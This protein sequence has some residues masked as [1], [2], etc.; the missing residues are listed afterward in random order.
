MRKR[1]YLDNNA[2][3][4]LDPR[5]I[6]V[7]TAEINEIPANPSS[8]HHFGHEARTK[9]TKA[10]RSIATCLNT[11][12]QEIIF[13][14]SGTEAIN[15]LLRGIFEGNPSGHVITS[16]VEHPAVFHTLKALE[17][18]GVQVSYLPV[19]AWGAVTPDIVEKAIRGDTRL[20]TLM[21]A[22][23]ET[24]VMTDLAAI[25]AIAYALKIPFVV[26]GVAWLGKAPLHI[27]QGVSAIAFSGH[28][29]H[30]PKGIGFAFVK[31]DLPLMPIVTGGGQEYNRRSGTENLAAI[32]A[33]AEA[34]KI[35]KDNEAHSIEHISRLRC[36]F[37]SNLLN[38]LNNLLIAGEGPK[39]ANTSNIAF[40]G[41][42]AE[43]FLMNLDL[44][45]IAASHGSACSSGALEP[46]RVLTNMGLTREAVKSSIR[47]SLSRYT[48]EEEIL[49]AVEVIQQVIKRLRA[50]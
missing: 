39:I 46:S 26:D 9:L 25:G 41:I 4:A 15:M 17:M 44:L 19:G 33:L 24:G 27:P 14:G 1:I 20:I 48:T 42:D 45:G 30:A 47:F 22:N 21:A 13:T 37:E 11:Q 34:V 31:E 6:E 2:T 16:N 12:P 38:S 23:N 3:T 29:V 10:R 43:S 8:I 32:I 36:L 40:S 18:K 28:K 5:V 49:R 50:L 7:F 35:L